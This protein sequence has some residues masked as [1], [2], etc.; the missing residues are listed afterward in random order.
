ML[1]PCIYTASVVAMIKVLHPASILHRQR[2]TTHTDFCWR[3]LRIGEIAETQWQ[4]LTATYC[5][6]VMH[7]HRDLPVKPCWDFMHRI[8]HT[9]TEKH[10]MVTST[11]RPCTRKA[12][13]LK[14]SYSVSTPACFSKS[15]LLARLRFIKPKAHS[16][17]EL[18]SAGFHTTLWICGWCTKLPHCSLIFYYISWCHVEK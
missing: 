7:K 4:L 6:C 1:S 9:F 11:E 15:I 5:C 18:S 8:Y 17:G 3:K 13:A 16:E 10:D 14:F 12:T 2:G